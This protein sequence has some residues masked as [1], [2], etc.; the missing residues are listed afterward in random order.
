MCK[1]VVTLNGEEIPLRDIVNSP[2]TFKNGQRLK[3]YDPRDLPSF[4]ARLLPEFDRRRSIRD[5]FKRQSSSA[6]LL[7][8]TPMPPENG[9]SNTSITTT[10]KT[11]D[12]SG[13]FHTLSPPAGHAGRKRKIPNQVASPINK[14]VRPM[15]I[16]QPTLRDTKGQ[17][18]LKT[19]F[20]PKQMSQPK[21]SGTSPAQR[22]AQTAPL[23]AF[24]DPS[25]HMTTCPTNHGSGIASKS[26]S[27][28]QPLGPTQAVE[29]SMA[30]L[31]ASP[32]EGVLASPSEPQTVFDPIVSKE[33]WTKL[34][35]KPQAPLCEGHE[36]PCIT[37][38]TKK[39]GFNCGR[40][41]WMCSR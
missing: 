31:P 21:S 4:S 6:S 7:N 35:T 2:G 34:F 12:N 15:S 19:F 38:E 3:E 32:G 41:F 36:E 29:K 39:K 8:E 9:S 14:R 27:G 10:D 37:L 40:S 17:Q 26:Q 23:T 24:A 1:S 16:L 5:M 25:I 22:M 20:Q 30:S 33:E 13:S 11:L 18:S 28:F